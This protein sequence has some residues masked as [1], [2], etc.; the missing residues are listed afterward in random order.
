MT[1]FASRFKKAEDVLKAP[2]TDL[3]SENMVD[4]GFLSDVVKENLQKNI[5]NKVGVPFYCISAA[6][7]G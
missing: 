5:D 7:G 6:N 1:H 4:D 2:V 3:G